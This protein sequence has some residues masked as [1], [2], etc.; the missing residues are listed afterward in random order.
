MSDRFTGLCSMA[1][2][3]VGLEQSE[4]GDRGLLHETGDS[5]GSYL[6]WRSERDD[7][8]IVNPC[9]WWGRR[10]RC[11]FWWEAEGDDAAGS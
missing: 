2:D 10:T 7:V 5:I 1:S 11:W 9:S 6:T 3:E 8:S 4:A